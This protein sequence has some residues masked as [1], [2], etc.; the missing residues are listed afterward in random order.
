MFTGLVCGL[1]DLTLFI[2][3]DKQY[4][5]SGELVTVYGN[6]SRDG[7][8][9][10]NALIAIEV[11]DPSTEQPMLARTLT[12]G[13]S[14][15]P[16]SIRISNFML[17]DEFGNPKNEFKRGTNLNFNIT[18][19]NTDTISMRYATVTVN[20]CYSTGEYFSLTSTRLP[21]Y[22]SQAVWWK[23]SMPIPANAHVGEAIAYANAYT[24]LPKENGIAYCGEEAVTFTIT[25]DSSSPSSSSSTNMQSASS[26]GTYDLTFRLRSKSSLGDHTVYASYYQTL[27]TTTFDVVWRFSDINRDG[28]VGLADLFIIAKAFGSRPGDQH[29]NPEADI[30]SDDLISILD[31]Y[32]VAR[33]YGETRT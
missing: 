2:S 18:L 28:K 17:C 27:A 21:V 32:R 20:L 6:V 23:C 26:E 24:K 8:P 7:S 22:P 9:V 29:W 4:Y 16:W 15:S 10:E 11:D 31:L 5:S 19:E 12:L 30:N 25:D 14:P 33:D 3:T 1:P 13:V